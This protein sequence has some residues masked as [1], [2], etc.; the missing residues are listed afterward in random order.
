MDVD[1]QISHAAYSMRY[2]LE[3]LK[4]TYDI[5]VDFADKP[6]KYCETWFKTCI[7][8]SGSIAYEVFQELPV[9]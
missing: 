5:G 6:D 8:E 7:D 9:R 3:A 1:Q 4:G 2:C